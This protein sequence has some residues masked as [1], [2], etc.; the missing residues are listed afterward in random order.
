MRVTELR[1][2]NYFQWSEIAS[3]GIGKD[4]ITKDNHYTYEDFKEPI[5]LTEDWLKRFGFA[6]V[7]KESGYVGYRVEWNVRNR[8]TGKNI[9]MHVWDCGDGQDKGYWGV[10]I[11]E[12]LT[13]DDITPTA[14]QYVHTLQNLY[15]DLTGEE[16]TYQNKEDE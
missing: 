6:R 16:L 8:P 5:P 15:F 9:S 3:M 2:G 11:W 10:T 13:I 7:T 4:V 1:V 12:V 14:I